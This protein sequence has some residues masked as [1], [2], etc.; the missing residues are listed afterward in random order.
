MSP[1]SGPSTSPRRRAWSRRPAARRARRPG[2]AGCSTCRSGGWRGAAGPATWEMA[3]M[4]YE[5]R[6]DDT[7]S[8][9]Y[10]RR[11]FAFLFFFRAGA[12]R[13]RHDDGAPAGRR[14]RV[15]GEG[16]GM[17]VRE[18]GYHVLLSYSLLLN[19][20]TPTRHGTLTCTCPRT[21]TRHR[22]ASRR[23]LSLCC[24]RRPARRARPTPPPSTYILPPNRPTSLCCTLGHFPGQKLRLGGDALGADPTYLLYLPSRSRGGLRRIDFAAWPRTATFRLKLSPESA[25]KPLLHTRGISRARSFDLG[26][27]SK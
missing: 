12:E 5:P 8:R 15:R 4:M 2:T 17:Y 10:V 11:P 1:W 23:R 21:Q 20:R 16:Q 18:R 6:K 14:G 13:R 25:H 7:R 27:G 19:I 24:W 9:S 3:T 26:A 22:K